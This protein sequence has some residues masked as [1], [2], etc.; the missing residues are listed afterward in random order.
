ME[1]EEVAQH[2]LMEEVCVEA[3]EWG[4]QN[5]LRKA[6]VQMAGVQSPVKLFKKGVKQW[7]HLFF[8]PPLVL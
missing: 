1:Q 6:P 3:S 4:R 2:V 5:E 7:Q 8:P